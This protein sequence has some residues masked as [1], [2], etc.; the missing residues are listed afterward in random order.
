MNMARAFIFDFDGVL[1]DTEREKFQAL[2]R[3]V[4]EYGLHMHD[5]LFFQM[6]GKKTSF[7]LETAFPRLSKERREEIAQKR[8]KEQRVHASAYK[9]ITGAKRLL[10]HLKKKGF[11]LALT[12][13]TDRKLVDLFLSHHA[14]SAIFDHLITGERFTKSKPDPE[15]YKMTLRC[16]R[17]APRDAIIIEDSLAGVAAGKK[18]GCTVFAITT[19]YDEIALSGADKVF[20]SHND[21]LRHLMATNLK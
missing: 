16:L 4:E 12:T 21:I 2:Q 10:L 6:I 7:F 9:P 20:K 17:I 3:L 8:R 5:D 11:A 19:Y 14:M 13:G 18:A 15:G 1:V